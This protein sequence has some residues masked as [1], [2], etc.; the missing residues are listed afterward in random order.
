MTEIAAPAVSVTKPRGKPAQMLADL[1]L[2]VYVIEE[3]EGNIDRYIL[4]RRLA[5]ERRTGS[6]FLRGIQ[7]KKL[8]TSAIY[9]REHFEIVID[10]HLV[11]VEKPDRK[12]FN[13]ALKELELQPQEAIYIGDL[14]YV[15][16]WGANQA[17]IGAIH[18][19]N[20]GLYAGWAGVHLPSVGGL[21]NWLA[22]QNGN[23]SPEI[24]YPAQDF[25]IN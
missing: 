2:A 6:T 11:G 25:E 24:L 21:P 20:M 18:L 10:S 12:I 4:S 23:L 3:D 17:G 19:D 7:D 14:F 9:L 22:Q 15:D 1:G 13:L 5:V 16:V 8:F